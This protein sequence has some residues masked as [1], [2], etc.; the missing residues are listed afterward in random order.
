MFYTLLKAHLFSGATFI[1]IYLIKTILLVANKDQALKKFTKTLKVPEMIV[2]AL[3]LLTGIYLAT[4]TAHQGA[5]IY[6]KAALVLAAIPLA[7]IG[8][9]K[10][11]KVLAILSFVLLLVVYRLGETKSLSFKKQK[12]ESSVATDPNEAAEVLYAN[13]C[14]S[15]H[16]MQGEMGLSGAKLLNASVLSLEERIQIILNGKNA[17]ASYKEQLTEEQIKAV[18]AYTMTFKK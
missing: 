10:H 13:K 6:V 1:L 18:A 17:M 5:W 14:S 9:K 3:F 16:G 2:S 12:I 11:N 8:F 4:Q 15:C 7:I